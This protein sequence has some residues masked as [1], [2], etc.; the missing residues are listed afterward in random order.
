MTG[1]DDMNETGRWVAVMVQ[2]GKM[3]AK[4]NQG[5]VHD[6]RLADHLCSHP[7]GMS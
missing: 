5:G 3:A 1:H 2:V 6:I 4:N 7:C